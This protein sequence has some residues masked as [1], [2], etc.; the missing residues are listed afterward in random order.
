MA[1]VGFDVQGL[2]PAASMNVGQAADFNFGHGPFMYAPTDGGRLSFQSIS[3]AVILTAASGHTSMDRVRPREQS[4]FD[5]RRYIA[6]DRVEAGCI[7][8][9]AQADDNVHARD[10]DGDGDMHRDGEEDG[11]RLEI[12]RQALVENMIGMGFPVEWAIRAAGRSGE[13]SK[14]GEVDHPS[15][16]RH[17]RL[18]RQTTCRLAVI[19]LTLISPGISDTPK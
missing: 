3:E 12:E 19:D 16:S 11:G 7:D 2:Y 17:S 13:L 18:L 8:D 1:F 9:D 4:A 15:T 10:S 14:K 5:V 6:E